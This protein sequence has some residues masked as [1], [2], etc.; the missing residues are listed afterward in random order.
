MVGLFADMMGPHDHEFE[1]VGQT[2]PD[3]DRPAT[4]AKGGRVLQGG[5]FLGGT[6]GG[7]GVFGVPGPP[8]GI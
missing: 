2:H 6:D 7:K 4:V 8:G 3:T 1:H 5:D